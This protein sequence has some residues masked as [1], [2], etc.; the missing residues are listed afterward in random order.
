MACEFFRI[1]RPGL[2]NFLYQYSGLKGCF[3]SQVN[4]Y[5]RKFHKNFAVLII[6]LS[7]ANE[8]YQY[9]YFHVLNVYINMLS[10]QMMSKPHAHVIWN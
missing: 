9:V 7:C 4:I 2:G 1:F 8:A 3:F 6:I 5:Y 10:F